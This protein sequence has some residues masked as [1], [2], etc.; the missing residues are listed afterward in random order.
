VGLAVDTGNTRGSNKYLDIEEK[1]MAK[2][3][4]DSQS[5]GQILLDFKLEDKGKYISQEFQDYG[6]RIAMELDDEKHK[7]LYIKLAK[8]EKRE[9]LE[10]ARSFVKDAH[11]VRSRARLFMWVLKKIRKGEPLYDPPK[12]E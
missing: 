9:V 10:R 7:A 4:G 1:I 6:Y 3:G 12:N 5:V 8:E 11:Q 2:R